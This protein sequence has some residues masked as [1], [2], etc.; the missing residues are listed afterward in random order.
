MQSTDPIS[1]I[2]T[3]I[4][5]KEPFYGHFMLGMPKAFDNTIE[6]A[7]VSLLSAHIVKLSVNNDFWKG[8]HENHQYGLIKH[9]ILHVV[10][11]H[12]FIQRDYTN[13][14]LFNIAADLVV[15]QYIPESQLPDGAL[16]LSTF[17]YLQTY[18]GVTL[19]PLQSTAY[20]YRKLLDCLQSSSKKP[21]DG[22]MKDCPT[23]L[24]D[25]LDE[26]NEHQKKHARWRQF[27]NLSQA[28][29]KIMEYQL[30][31]H[32]K[33][34][35]ERFKNKPKALGHL[36][37]HLLEYLND[38]LDSYKPQIDW[39]RV[40]KKFAASSTSSF[41]KNT[42]RRPS[43]RYGTTPGIKVKRHHRLLVA[44]DTSG[45]VPI[46]D[47]KAFFGELHHIWKQGAEV[48][49]T[50]CDAAIHK[51]Y[52]YTGQIP[53]T[54]SGRGGTSLTPPISLANKEIR[55]DGIIYFTDGCAAPP[56]VKSRCP[57]LWIITSN[58]IEND[59]ALWSQL[60]GQKVKMENHG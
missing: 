13:K 37:G 10:L 40:L 41:I 49:I 26:M 27:E 44:L 56:S 15:N 36:P 20:Y 28:E 5:L 4:L 57:V 18:Y 8:L 7:C 23:T 22:S 35:M 47:I 59:N 46:A 54:I 33:N 29:V 14:A 39:K 60:P 31:N 21:G 48:I 11:K 17:A 6:T 42:L 38:F 25:L 9:E 3:R 50:E 52:T 45:S 34:V 19:E 2:T 32:V 24:T 30:Y 43:K 1:R 53:D 51:T 58:G 55:P 16:K 12:L